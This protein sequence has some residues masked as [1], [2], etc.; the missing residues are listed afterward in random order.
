MRVVIAIVFCVGLFTIVMCRE[1]AAQQ[2]G[3]NNVMGSPRVEITPTTPEPLV[4]PLKVSAN[5]RYLVDQ[6]NQPFLMVGDAPQ[7]IVATLSVDEA[8]RYMENRR[9]YGINTLWVNLLCNFSDGCNKEAKTVDGEAP[10]LTAGDLSK[11]NPRYFQRVDDIVRLAAANGMV[12]L[13]DPIE[14]TS[15]LPTLRAAGAEQAFRYG[16]YLGR[17]FKDF[18][19]IIWMHG[20]DFQSWRD[21]TDDKL[22]KAVARGIRSEDQVH[23]HTIELNYLTSGSLD[24][25]DW[26]PLIELDAAYTYFPTFAQVLAE[27]NRTE[28]K[29]VFMVEANYEFERDIEGLPQ[30]LRRQE[31]WTMLSG[32]TGQVYGSAYTW[33]LEK[34]WE[35]KLDSPGAV[36]LRLMKNLFA[37]RK[38]YDLIPDQD[39]AVVVDGYDSISEFFGKLIV[40]VR[41]LRLHFDFVARLKR[42]AP[43][44]LISTNT[45]ASAARSSDGS[46]VMA[47][48]PTVRTVTVDMS[49]LAG[50]AT[51][52][53]YDPTSGKYSEIVGSPFPNDGSR[54]IRPPGSNAAGDGDWVLVLEVGHQSVQQ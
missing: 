48:L 45:F 37:E 15:W 7:T 50:S 36:Q 10:F 26:A 31:Y 40:Y 35:S 18:P 28:F 41:D 13:L 21:V 1:G 5:H 54:Q 3:P 8:A 16:Q 47:Y 51:A 2:I 9:R 6:N 30:N 11:P 39:H 19:N 33:R 25:P 49:K 52:R 27:Y 14:T 12:V 34:D 23:I 24:D 32:A 38:W 42:Y 20:N 22:V 44:V 17:R 46:L 29:P 53:W 4:Y 43:H